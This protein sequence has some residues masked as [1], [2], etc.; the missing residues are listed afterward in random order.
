MADIVPAA[1][2]SRMMS[3]IR[4]KDTKPEL[5]LRKGL[6]NAGFRFRLH[7][8]DLPGTPD[9]VLPG[10]NAVVL[11][12][13]CFWHGHDCPLFKLPS[14]RQEFWQTKIERNRAVDAKTTAALKELGWRV[15]VVWECALKGRT[16]LPLDDVIGACTK[17]L[18]SDRPEL[19][20]RG[21]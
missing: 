7:R 1:V 3:G 19:E 16:R 6:H 4:A 8:R 2:R 15:G 10:Y 18:R 9:I 14:T 12:H 21:K 5:V 20:I 11:A 17:W 13:G